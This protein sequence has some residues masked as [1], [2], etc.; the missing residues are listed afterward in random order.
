MDQ[1]TPVMTRSLRQL[2][3]AAFLALAVLLPI[4]IFLALAGRGQP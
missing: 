2:H 1:G 4:L 3:R